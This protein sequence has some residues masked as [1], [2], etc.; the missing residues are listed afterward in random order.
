MEALNIDGGGSDVELN[1]GSDVES[2]S[3][4]E[5]GSKVGSEAGSDV[6]SDIS[7]GGGPV[8]ACDAGSTV[9]SDSGRLLLDGAALPAWLADGLSRGLFSSD[10]INLISGQPLLQEPQVSR[11]NTEWCETQGLFVA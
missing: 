1:D 6:E 9:T 8:S 4:S 2:D 3:G 5:G 11:E 10:V 7:A